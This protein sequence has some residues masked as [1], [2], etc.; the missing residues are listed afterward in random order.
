MRPSTAPSGDSSGAIFA[1]AA[2]SAVV[3]S[4]RVPSSLIS[5][6]LKPL[7]Q[8]KMS[9]SPQDPL[10]SLYTRVR[11]VLIIKKKSLFYLNVIEAAPIRRVAV[12]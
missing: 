8:M 9:P 7:L 12:Q 2:S 5:V 1:T 10:T 6:L 11:K 3:P 4:L